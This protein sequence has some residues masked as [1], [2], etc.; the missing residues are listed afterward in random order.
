MGKE[1]PQKQGDPYKR[2]ILI[3]KKVNEQLLRFSD[4]V[5]EGLKRK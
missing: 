4:K 2:D 1:F 3:R 5:S